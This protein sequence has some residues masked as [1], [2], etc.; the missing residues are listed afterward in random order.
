MAEEK[1]SNPKAFISYSWTSP[2]HENWVKSLA[3]RL[4]SDGIDVILDKWELREG[5]DKYAFMER[6]VTDET[7]TKVLAICDKQYAEKAD[8]RKGGVGTES[9][10]ISKEVYEKVDQKK[11]IAI[12]TGYDEK[13]KAYVPTYFA[14][15]I[16]ID[17]TTE[18]KLYENYDR[19]LRAIFDKPLDVKP[20]LGT[21]PSYLFEDAGRASKTAHKLISL[22]RAVLDGKS[23]V[24]GLIADYLKSYS[25]ALEDYRINGKVTADYD[26]Q[27]ISSIEKFIPYRDEFIDFITFISIYRDDD[28]TYQEIFEFFQDLL[29]YIHPPESTGQRHEYWFDNY[30]FILFELFLYHITILIKNQRFEQVNIFLSQGYFDA[31]RAKRGEGTMFTY[32]IFDQYPKSIEELRKQ[33]LK[34]RYYYVTADL[35]QKRAHNKELNFDA[36]IETDFIL[37]LRSVLNP[38][39]SYWNNWNART[40]AHAERH[41]VFEIFAKAASRRYFN[42]L[43]ILLNVSSKEDLEAK[44]KAVAEYGRI[45]KGEHM[46]SLHV[47]SLINIENLDTYN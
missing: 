3:E 11:F 6:M 23:S 47:D 13:G 41:F 42:N 18:E 25:A 2:E 31:Y 12:V 1:R 28:R 36:L 22:K 37:F 19:L 7:V 14:S 34:L 32:G 24:P 30:R 4:V 17:M 26:E 40:A 43:K 8:K 38:P 33:R 46:S 29:K 44:Y 20:S 27:V 15:R 21:P 10:I 9:Q 5:Q 45:N 35:L 39:K 16:F